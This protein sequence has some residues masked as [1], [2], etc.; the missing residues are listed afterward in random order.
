MSLT[1]GHQLAEVGV[2]LGVR[3]RDRLEVL[4]ELERQEVGHGVAPSGEVLVIV[5]GDAEHLADDLD[6]VVIGELCHELASSGGARS[7]R[8]ARRPARASLPGTARPIVA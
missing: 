4:A 3:S 8:P 7:R 2:Q 1:V 5:L 6:G